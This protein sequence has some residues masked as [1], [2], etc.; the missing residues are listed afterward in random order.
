[1][2]SIGGSNHVIRDVLDNPSDII[3]YAQRLATFKK[4]CYDKEDTPCSS[5]KLARAGFYFSG[6]RAD[7]SAATC[8]FCKKE[9]IFDATDDPWAEHKSHSE[10]CVFV[11]L[12]KLDE[13]EWTVRDFL[14]LAT[15]RVAAETRSWMLKE[16]DKFRSGADDVEK[17]ATSKMK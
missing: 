11:E 10:H 8:A 6:T 2:T 3:F 15:G 17:M 4:W 12:N 7:P 5:E 9:M 1:M 13:T 16:A 14:K